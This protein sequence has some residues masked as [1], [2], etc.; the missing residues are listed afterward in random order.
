MSVEEEDEAVD[1]EM[2]ADRFRFEGDLFE[3]VDGIKEIRL[4]G[5]FTDYEHDEVAEGDPRRLRRLKVRFSKPVLMG[6][7]LTTE[8]WSEGRVVPLRRV[9]AARN[10]PGSQGVRFRTTIPER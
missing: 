1:I 4:R 5:V 6:D 9:D 8:G 7:T 3:P 2:E 10:L